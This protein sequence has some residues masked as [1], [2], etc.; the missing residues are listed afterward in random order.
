PPRPGG[1]GQ[2]A[3]L[4]ERPLRLEPAG[5]T[6]DQPDQC[7]AFRSFYARSRHALTSFHDIAPARISRGPGRATSTIVDGAPPAV[8]PPSTKRSITSPSACATASG[9]SVGGLPLMF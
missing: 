5:T 7:G 9:S 1:F 4:L 8:R 6:G 3:E 2:P